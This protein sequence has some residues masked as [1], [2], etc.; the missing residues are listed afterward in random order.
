MRRLVV[1]VDLGGSSTEDRL[2]PP[3]RPAPVPELVQA[4]IAHYQTE[5]S[6]P[7]DVLEV[8]FFHG[9]MPC[10]DVLHAA[11]P[12]PVRLS[13]SPAD[14]RRADVPFLLEH[15]VRTIELDVCTFDNDVLRQLNRGYRA[16][17]V[18]AQ[19]RALREH[20]VRLGATLVPGLPGGS[21]Q[22]SLL[23]V[24]AL[25]DE[26]G[27][28]LVDFVRLCPALALH[29]AAVVRWVEDGWWRPMRLGEA[30]TTLVA[31]MDKCDALGIAVA[32][33]GLQVG[34]D[35]PGKVIAG[36]QHPNLRQLVEVRRFYRR[37][38]MLVKD[39]IPG[40]TVRLAVHPGDVAWTKG[41]AN[42]N[43][44]RLR[45]LYSLHAVEIQQ[46]DRLNRGDVIVVDPSSQ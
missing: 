43:I 1:P 2:R 46:D 41:T 15:N 34:A 19:L 12:H 10:S 27:Q 5:R 28:P 35:V 31:M 32:R 4:L 6:Q 23:D 40:S 38:E 21:H 8:G 18:I 44:R 37:M 29:G 30:V 36:P 14:L 11:R 17:Q 26:D 45:A 3:L 20:G 24:D 13:C 7:G 9:G 25:V 22:Q 16:Q 33:V 39:S 42:E